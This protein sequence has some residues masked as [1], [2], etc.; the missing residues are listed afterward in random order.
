MGHVKPWQWG[1]SSSVTAA[2]AQTFT[3]NGPNGSS[4]RTSWANISIPIEF[5]GSY[6]DNAAPLGSD[7]YRLKIGLV[8]ARE[9][10]LQ[11]ANFMN[12]VGYDMSS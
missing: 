6:D 8:L 11:Q 1:A 5:S 4:N 9:P 12:Q 10:Q 3:V 2:R 7:D